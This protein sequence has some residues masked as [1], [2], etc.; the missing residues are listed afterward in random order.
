MSEKIRT[1]VILAYRH[2]TLPLRALYRDWGVYCSVD[3]MQLPDVV[4]A[5][6]AAILGRRAAV[7][8]A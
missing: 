5:E 7:K 2:E 8:A 1:I 4:T 6:I 3:G